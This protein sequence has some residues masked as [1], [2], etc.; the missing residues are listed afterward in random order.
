MTG[1]ELHSLLELS[2]SKAGV[3]LRKFVA[4]LTNHSET[5]LSQ[6]KQA[7]KP[8]PRTIERISALLDGRPIP[9]GQGVPAGVVYCTRAEREARGL[10]PS[11]RMKLE[12]SSLA[13][14]KAAKAAVELSRRLTEQA[15]ASRRPGQTIADRVAPAAISAARLPL[16]GLRARRD[17]GRICLPVALVQAD[18]RPARQAV[19]RPRGRDPRQRPPRPGMG[20]CRG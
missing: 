12:T 7:Q 16:A 6:L 15:H 10:P 3:G 5:F 2:A 18:P 8:K 17:A 1:A 13:A 20:R 9:A 19:E 4:P 14:A 11:H